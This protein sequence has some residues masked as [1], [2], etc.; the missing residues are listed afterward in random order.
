MKLTAALEHAIA[1]LKDGKLVA[2]PTETVYGLAGNAFSDQ[3]IKLIYAIKNR[4]TNNPLIVH[5][6]G[7]QE[8]H[9]VAKNIP[10]AALKLADLFWP[11]P[12]TLVLEKQDSIS[13]LITAGKDTV[14][15]RVPDHK[16]T[17]KLLASIDFPL[18]APSANRSNHISPTSP[19][20]VRKSLGEKA[21]YVLDGGNCTKG[22]EST[23]VG[24]RDEEVL[25]YRRGAIGKE[26]LENALKCKIKEVNNE[27][28]P[29]SPGMFKKHYSPNTPLVIFKDLEPLLSRYKDD[30]IGVISFQGFL[31]LSE[32]VVQKVLSPKGNLNEYA[33]QLYATLYEMDEMNFDL[34]LIEETPEVGIGSAIN[35]R[36]RRAAYQEV[37]E[38]VENHLC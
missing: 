37:E 29:Q 3:A 18:V 30:K 1:Q 9:K 20:H 5:V 24:F 21:P 15:V 27:I 17:L 23:I 33:A 25:L 19:D 22:I 28:S 4:P 38:K 11:G 7:K 31:N 13:D 12:L 8:M 34:I 26:Q 6:K 16:L 35:D 36:I 2:I 32:K 14:G 10:E